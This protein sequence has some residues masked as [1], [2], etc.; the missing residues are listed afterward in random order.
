MVEIAQRHN[1]TL[2]W[3]DAS[4]ERVETLADLFWSTRPRPKLPW[5]RAAHRRELA[6]VAND[7]GAYIG[8]VFIRN[9]GGSWGWVIDASG[10][11][12]P[13]VSSIGGQLF[14]PT[15]RAR[16]RL[17]DGP[18]NNL[19]HYYLVLVDD[20]SKASPRVTLPEAD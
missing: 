20:E 10:G 17:T 6:G 16:N 13:G 5:S 2:D 9:H 8:E 15:G 7:L 3:S 14:W 18:E 19:W 11:R 4:V 12:F 1:V